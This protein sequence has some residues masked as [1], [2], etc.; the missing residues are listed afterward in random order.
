MP[1]IAIQFVLATVLHSFS[2]IYIYILFYGAYIKVSM[3]AIDFVRQIA[4]VRLRND[5]RKWK[6]KVSRSANVA[7]E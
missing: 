4:A 1:K 7:F 2:S 5:N 3:Y 6:M